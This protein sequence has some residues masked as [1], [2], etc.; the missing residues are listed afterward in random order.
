[1]RLERDD[2]DEI[3]I[4]VCSCLVSVCQMSDGCMGIGGR[5]LFM[6]GLSS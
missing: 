6:A 5:M 1:M 3:G 4:W 2:A